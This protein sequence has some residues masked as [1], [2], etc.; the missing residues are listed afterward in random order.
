MNQFSP[1][2]EE[3]GVLLSS[4]IYCHYIIY[5]WFSFKIPFL[6]LRLIINFI[7]N[8]N[9]LYPFSGVRIR[10]RRFTRTSR[11]A[12]ARRTRRLILFLIFFVIFLSSPIFRSWP[13]SRMFT[14][15]FHVIIKILYLL[16]IEYYNVYNL[17]FKYLKFS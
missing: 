5:L 12:R 7:F 14:H 11:R 8:W 4:A 10:F 2:V 17:L 13:R 6:I 3:W 16:K 15:F 9:R 1:K